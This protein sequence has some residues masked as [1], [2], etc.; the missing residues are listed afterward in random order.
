MSTTTSPLQ[1]AQEAQYEKRF[2]LEVWG[3]LLR[4]AMGHKI[5]LAAL[6]FFG[7]TTALSDIGFPWVTGA[8][9]DEVAQK[10]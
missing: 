7:F 8:L 3:K 6:A 2:D 4:Y 5:K 1:G 9:I 10:G